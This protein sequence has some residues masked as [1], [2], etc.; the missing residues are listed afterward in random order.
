[1]SSSSFTNPYRQARELLQITQQEVAER[2]G[3]SPSAVLFNEQG[4]YVDPLPV[5][6]E[7]F[8]MYFDKEAL[9]RNYVLF[10]KKTRR[11]NQRMWLLPAPSISVHPLKAVFDYNNITKTRF[12]KLYC[13]QPVLLRAPKKITGYLKYCFKQAGFTEVQIQ[14]ISDRLE[15]YHDHR[16]IVA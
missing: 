11:E 6:T 2:A 9:Q 12:T 3:C 4:I 15:E 1:V 14:E 16:R 8:G 7:F 10:Q 5:L 13:V